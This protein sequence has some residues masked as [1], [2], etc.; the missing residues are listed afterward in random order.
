MV[1]VPAAP[2][3]GARAQDIAFE[4][5]ADDVEGFRVDTPK[6]RPDFLVLPL[7]IA[8]P[9]TGA[10][11][12]LAGV[13]F[14][15]PNEAP[16]PW[17][18]G[19]GLV[20]TSNGANGIG[21]L[22]SMSLDDD[23][24]RIKLLAGY[25]D[26][27]VRF[28]GI[29]AEAGDRNIHVPLRQS[30]TVV[31]IE[32]QFQLLRRFYGGLRYTFLNVNA[33]PDT[34]TRQFTVAPPPLSQ[35]SST[36]SSLAPT[37]AYDRRD[38]SLNPQHGEYAS[39]SLNF[40]TKALGSDF[41]SRKFQLAANLYRPLFL[42]T[43]LALRGALCWASASSPYYDLCKFGA[44]SDLR[45]YRSDRYRDGATW[46]FQGEVRRQLIGRFGATAFVGLGGVASHVSKFRKGRSLPAA[47]LGLRYTATKSNPVNF[48]LDF[49]FGRDSSGAYLSLGEA[50]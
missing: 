45:G 6:T 18:T 4:H 47:G 17:I 31:K 23:Q 20:K 37:L 35:L 32:A 5:I 33:R 43:T 25:I 13:A 36:V 9:A 28:Y 21:A 3:A 19:V 41:S 38:N 42:R 2:I 40:A 26:T 50:F 39:F 24:I 16:E 29:G 11:L 15:N 27:R 7:P 34:L 49:A 44:S 10:G 14:Y 48:R 12:V 22:H 8:G 30:D 46:A 1:A